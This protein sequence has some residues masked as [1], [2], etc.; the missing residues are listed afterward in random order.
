MSDQIGYTRF[1]SF[2]AHYKALQKFY[3]EDVL[4]LKEKQITQD[5]FLDR[6]EKL[7][8][9]FRELPQFMT[10]SLDKFADYVRKNISESEGTE[11]A[12]RLRESTQVSSKFGL[13]VQ[14]AV[15]FLSVQ[16]EILEY[17]DMDAA[18]SR[19]PKDEILM[20]WQNDLPVQARDWPLDKLLRYLEEEARALPNGSPSKNVVL[21]ALEVEP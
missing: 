14:Y 18:Y 20:Y 13:S 6:L 10:D 17:G 1:S 15:V 3:R 19:V 2:D 4:G 11:N 7:N 12:D 5:C 16:K 21:E 8:T 9:Q